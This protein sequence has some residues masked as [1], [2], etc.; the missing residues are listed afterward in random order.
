[1]KKVIDSMGNIIYVPND[2]E[3]IKI[4]FK[5]QKMECDCLSYHPVFIIK[6]V[7]ENDCTDQDSQVK[8]TSANR[9]WWHIF[10]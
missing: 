7:T 4:N 5:M 10:K 2:C 6:Y 1:M 3:T 9:S 8:K